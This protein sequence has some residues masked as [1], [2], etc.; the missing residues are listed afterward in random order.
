MLVAVGLQ[1]CGTAPAGRFGSFVEVLQSTNAVYNVIRMVTP[2]GWNDL[3]NSI[4]KVPC[5]EL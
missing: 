1:R 2:S 3:R 5:D 4:R